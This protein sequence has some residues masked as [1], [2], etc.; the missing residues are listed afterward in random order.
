MTEWLPWK[1]YL[2]DSVHL[3]SDGPLQSISS[4]VTI[5]QMIEELMAAESCCRAFLPHFTACLPVVISPADV[6]PN[7][8]ACYES[9]SNSPGL[10]G[11]P[12][13]SSST[14]HQRLVGRGENLWDIW[15]ILG[16]KWAQWNTCFEKLYPKATSSKYE[17]NFSCWFQSI[18]NGKC[19]ENVFWMYTTVTRHVIYFNDYSYSV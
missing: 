12:I 18:S 8:L 7:L 9:N 19:D 13:K 15:L 17:Y 16:A 10:R 3:K 11:R 1:Q 4:E 2:L 14:G 6:P 5:T